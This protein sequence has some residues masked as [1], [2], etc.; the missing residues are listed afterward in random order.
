[1]LHIDVVTLFPDMFAVPVQT[2]IL[3]RA[4]S[5][6]L[7]S[8]HVHQLRDWATGK[9]KTVDD[10]VFGGGNGMLLKPEPVFA[11]IEAIRR[12]GQLVVLVDPA[13]ERFNQAVACELAQRE[14]LLLLC[15]HYEGV[16]ERIREHLV[17]RELSIGDYILT[18]G[19]LAALVIVDAVSRLIPG[20]LAEGSARD[21][22]FA[23]SDTGKG[24]T[25]QEDLALEYPQ[26][27]RPAEFRGWRVPEVLL[28]GNHA[29][30]Q[31][32]RKEQSRLRTLARRP[33]LLHID[34]GRA[35]ST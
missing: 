7:L 17:D 31:A 13:G 25:G 14:Y 29:R 12:P 9:H 1:M 34:E 5:K 6:G 16:D 32:W 20:V 28:S 30:I 26:Y 8:V 3:G 35:T 10:Y 24:A 21:E 2:S 18:G 22:S 23:H 11:A 15:G 27:T 19:E 4:Q 33:D